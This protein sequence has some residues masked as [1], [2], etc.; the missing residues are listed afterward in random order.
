MPFP[1]RYDF[2]LYFL[3]SGVGSRG[4][5]SE[6][7]AWLSPTT[8]ALFPKMKNLMLGFCHL[9]CVP[10]PIIYL[11]KADD[12]WMGL[13][14][15][16]THIGLDLGH[17]RIPFLNY[18]GG[19]NG[20]LGP[21]ESKSTQTLGPAIFVSSHSLT[22]CLRE[23]MAVGH[24]GEALGELLLN[25]LAV[26]SQCH[27]CGDLTSLSALLETRTGSGPEA[28]QAIMTFCLGSCLHS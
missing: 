16:W 6:A 28:W 27:F 12:H 7:T 22:G 24:F 15:Q 13:W 25:T 26:V 20:A 8:I 1:L 2:V 9:S 3:S 10:I 21:W 17:D 11:G 23:L 5:I 4:D 14:T 18:N 19:R